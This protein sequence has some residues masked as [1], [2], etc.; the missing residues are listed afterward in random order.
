MSAAILK[1]C[2]WVRGVE[3]RNPIE[4]G[5]EGSCARDCVGP[6]KNPITLFDSERKSTRKREKGWKELR[7]M[8]ARKENDRFIEKRENETVVKES[9]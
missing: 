5:E 2:E 7:K 3:K 8:T 1:V 6:A 4:T 9:G